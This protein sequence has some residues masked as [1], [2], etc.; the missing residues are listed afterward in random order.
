MLMTSMQMACKGIARAVK[1]AGIADLYGAADISNASGDDVKKLDVLS[2]DIMC[3]ALINSMTC[4]VL[5]SEEQARFNCCPPQLTGAT[6]GRTSHRARRQ[7]WQLLCRIRS[8][9]WVFEYRELPLPIYR[10]DS[11]LAEGLF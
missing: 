11:S 7:T 3:S 6:A 2:N 10:D 9:G 4:A 5:V 8:P 1:K